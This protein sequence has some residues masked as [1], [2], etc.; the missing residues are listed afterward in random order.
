MTYANALSYFWKMIEFQPI[1]Q[2]Q[3]HGLWCLKDH[4]IYPTAMEGQNAASY[5][6]LHFNH[7]YF[8]KTGMLSLKRW[9]YCAFKQQ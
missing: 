4:V 9:K 5:I 8:L 6:S 3:E 1:N 2:K 7:R